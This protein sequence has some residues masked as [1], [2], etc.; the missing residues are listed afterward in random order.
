MAG[1]AAPSTP[2]SSY[3]DVHALLLSW[4]DGDPAI[5]NQLVELKN[6]FKEDYNYNVEEWAIPPE[7][8]YHALDGKLSR[9]L[10]NDGKETLL[11]LYYGG[12]GSSNSDKAAVWMR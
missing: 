1:Y 9:F 12:H 10:D 4:K 8:S 2:A 5:Y 3:L 6:V 7:N 11:I